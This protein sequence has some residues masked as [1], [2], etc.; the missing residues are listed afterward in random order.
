MISKTESTPNPYHGLWEITSRCKLCLTSSSHKLFTTSSVI[1]SIM[2]M[3]IMS[4]YV[5][6]YIHILNSVKLQFVLTWFV[7]LFSQFKIL[8]SLF[9]TKVVSLLQTQFLHFSPNQTSFNHGCSLILVH[10]SLA[11]IPSLKGQH[12]FLWVY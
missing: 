12:Y 6:V 3:C 11:L 1:I 7:N 9:G 5:C 2:Y 8:F 10:L 4:R